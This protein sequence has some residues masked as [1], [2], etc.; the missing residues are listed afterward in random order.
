MWRWWMYVSIMFETAVE[1]ADDSNIF[2]VNILHPNA[3]LAI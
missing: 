2:Y 3:C 1:V